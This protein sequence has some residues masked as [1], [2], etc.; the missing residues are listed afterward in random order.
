MDQLRV[1]LSDIVIGEP[2]Q[3]NVCDAEG[4]LLLRKGHIIESAHQ[5]EGL[6]ERGMYIDSRN[7]DFLLHR[8][9]PVNQL[10]LPSVL[11][12]L[13]LATKQLER[14][15]YG[16]SGETNVQAKVL[17]IV[18][19]ITHAVNLNGNI[20]F[21]CILLNQSV[22]Y[23]V[24]HSIDTAIVSLLVMRA[25]HKTPDEITAVMAAAL[26]MNV[27][28]LRYQDQIENNQ[29][30]LSEKELDVIKK[31]PEES[32]S[33]LKQAGIDNADWL[34]YVLSHHE[35]ED[36]SGY[37][38]GKNVRGIS[39]NTKILTFADCYCACITN[40]LCRKTLSHSAAMREVLLAGGKAR[41]P[42]LAAYF[43]KE[44]G[45]YPPGTFV[46]LQNGEIGIVTEKGADPATPI[47]HALIGPRGAPLA[48]PIKRNTAKLLHEIREPVT[49]EQ[50]TL[51]FSLQQLW[52]DEAKL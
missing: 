8:E 21:A 47:V 17:E 43:I 45:T 26:T 19:A 27:G 5:V 18:Q 40:R 38:L 51:R 36:G 46:R 1:N 30:A 11:R 4:H 23:A 2:L 25:M 33:I 10:E 52:G 44:L 49:G 6:M 13:N 34:S 24:R 35:N 22:N 28:M 7:A 32:V 41:D 29:G 15:L 48:Y 37:P 12:L 39:Q 3:W 9:A 31:H 20:A 14:L 16:L 50:A 42:M